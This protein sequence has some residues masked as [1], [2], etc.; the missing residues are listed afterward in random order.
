MRLQFTPT[1]KD[2]S[3]AKKYTTTPDPAKPKE[4]IRSPAPTPTP[5]SAPAPAPAPAPEQVTIAI[6]LTNETAAAAAAAP[7]DTHGQIGMPPASEPAATSAAKVKPKG[8][9]V[10][11]GNESAAE[12]G[13]ISQGNA[14]RAVSVYQGDGN[15]DDAG[16]DDI[17]DSD[18]DE[19]VIA[20]GLSMAMYGLRKRDAVTW[21]A[22]WKAG[23]EWPFKTV[24]LPVA[25]RPGTVVQKP[26][27]RKRTGGSSNRSRSGSDKKK[28]VR[29]PTVPVLAKM[30][31]D[32]LQNVC[33]ETPP[34]TPNGTQQ[35]P[36]GL[37][38]PR[39]GEMQEITAETLAV[40]PNE[41]L[42]IPAE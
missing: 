42:H 31:E 30:Q 24:S 4:A 40:S 21:T 23:D 34:E 8:V 28:R 32:G 7:G 12:R 17:D 10:E 5:T 39:P 20:E 3:K 38:P 41:H 13:R 11:Q 9:L 29:T 26:T 25:D 14:S 1:Q 15:A 19:D 22:S 35:L 16:A 6:K 33:P 2:K 27:K 18:S 36:V 37:L